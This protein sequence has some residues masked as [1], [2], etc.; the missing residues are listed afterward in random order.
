M[1]P[2][3]TTLDTNILRPLFDALGVEIGGTDAFGQRS[4]F[5]EPSLVG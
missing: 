1:N 3:V 5:G 4:F 2:L